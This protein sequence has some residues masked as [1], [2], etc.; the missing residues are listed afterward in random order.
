[1]NAF[2]ART[3]DATRHLFFQAAENTL[4]VN[5]NLATKSLAFIQRYGLYDSPMHMLLAQEQRDSTEGE[6]RRGVTP[7]LPPARSASASLPPSPLG[8]SNQKV[9]TR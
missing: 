7:P 6:H 8:S 1:M 5:N 9:R 3:F 2:R 4:K